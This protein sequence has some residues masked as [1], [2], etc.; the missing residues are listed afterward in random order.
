MFNNLRDTSVKLLCGA[1]F[2]QRLDLIRLGANPFTNRGRDQLRKHF[3]NRVTFAHEREPERLYTIQNDYLSCG[4]GNDYTQLFIS[5]RESGPQIAFFDHA[6]NLLHTEEREVKYPDGADWTRRAGI[7]ERACDKWLKELG[8]R[9][10]TINVKAFRFPN[11]SGLTPFNW[12]A[13]AYDD[14]PHGGQDL[15]DAVERWLE[16]GQYRFQFGGGSDAWFDRTGE[17]TDT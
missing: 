3:G 16:Q 9:S 13:E 17:V 14:Q 11:G 6:G 15:Q 12:W 8:Y 2:F 7:R 5:A 4:W 10:A 1:E